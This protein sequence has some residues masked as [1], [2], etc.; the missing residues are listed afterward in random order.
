MA[1]RELRYSWFEETRKSNGYG[2]IA[3][4]H[5][6]NDSIETML[7]NLV[8]GT[9]LTGLRGIRTVSGR[10]VRPLLFAS[11]ADIEEYARLNG[12][13][14]RE[15]ASNAET[16]YSRNKIRHKV[17]PVLKEINPSVERTLTESASRFSMLDELLDEYVGSAR[18]KVLTRSGNEFIINI[19]QLSSYF[20]NRAL[21]F[22]IF[23]VF[24]IS[25]ETLK[26]LETIAKGRTGS[27]ISAGGYRFIRNR[28]EIII[29]PGIENDGPNEYRV[30]G[31]G[32]FEAVPFI[33]SASLLAAGKS[34]AAPKG[35]E[36]AAIDASMVKYP[37]VFRR[38]KQGDYFYPF[39]QEGKK[40]LSDFFTDRKY[41]IIRKE[42][43]WILESE[44]NIVWIAGERPDRRF[45]VTEST[46]QVLLLKTSLK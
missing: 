34:F 17:L 37:L 46:G 38:W 45:I 15:D 31:P 8:R 19:K 13:E 10:I 26:D 36:Y 20:G 42:K 1:A 2:R 25:K 9:G 29:T 43:A 4:A 40:K 14:F 35:S 23:S 16:K 28:G 22:E 12:V 3:V 5:N 18:D 27:Y 44:G 30:E 11:R 33:E 7:I 6:S 32:G 39:G 41:S 21:L 24:G